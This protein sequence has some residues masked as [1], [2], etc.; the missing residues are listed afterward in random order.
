[1]DSPLQCGVESVYRGT[2]GWACSLA[3][4]P[5]RQARTSIPWQRQDDIFAH[6]TA[7]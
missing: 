3:W 1:M 2:I 6:H 4:A 7:K 5:E